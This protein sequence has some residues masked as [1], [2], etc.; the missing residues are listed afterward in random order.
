MASPTRNFC[1][2]ETILVDSKGFVIYKDQHDPA[3]YA[4]AS[5]ITWEGLIT[6]SRMVT[7]PEEVQYHGAV[8]VIVALVD[9]SGERQ[10]LQTIGVV[11]CAGERCYRIAGFEIAT[12]EDDYHRNLLSD[13]FRD[14]SRIDLANSDTSLLW[15]ANSVKVPTQT[16]IPNILMY[17]DRERVT[18]TV[19]N[20]MI[21]R[22]FD[23]Y[24]DARDIV[25]N[26]KAQFEGKGEIAVY[27]DGKLLDQG[28]HQESCAGNR[29]HSNKQKYLSQPADLYR[30][31][32]QRLLGYFLYYQAGWIY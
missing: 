12:V 5:T 20:R 30:A 16:T 1:R 23:V 13:D 28:L 31:S 24:V 32:R 14:Q 8:D 25:Y 11:Q 7:I 27:I 22:K 3:V 26:L 2:V 9:I 6:Y 19:N 15:R 29:R 17:Y 18:S 4:G 10:L 21:G